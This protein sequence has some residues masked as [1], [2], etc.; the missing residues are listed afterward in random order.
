VKAETWLAGVVIWVRK[1]NGIF[2]ANVRTN[3]GR[4]KTI[5]PQAMIAVDLA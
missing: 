2:P 4:N 1:I 5:A 3:Q